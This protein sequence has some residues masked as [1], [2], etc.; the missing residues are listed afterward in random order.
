MIP[1][2]G[3]LKELSADLEARLDIVLAFYPTVE[4]FAIGMNL[5]SC[6]KKYCEIKTADDGLRAKKIKLRELSAIYGESQVAGFNDLSVLF[7]KVRPFSTSKKGS[8]RKP[9]CRN[10]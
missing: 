9:L 10:E 3:R 8:P 6:L 1:Q 2:K 5:E 7:R 4:E